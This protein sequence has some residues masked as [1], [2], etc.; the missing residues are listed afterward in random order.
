MRQ[1]S[2]ALDLGWQEQLHF[3]DVLIF[4]PFIRPR[5]VRSNPH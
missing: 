2:Q 3:A 5:H 4:F 1:N